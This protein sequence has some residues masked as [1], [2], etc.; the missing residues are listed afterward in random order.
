MYNYLDLCVYVSCKCVCV[1]MSVLL[2]FNT[3]LSNYSL[4]HSDELIK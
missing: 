3:T 1:H 4:F 2:P